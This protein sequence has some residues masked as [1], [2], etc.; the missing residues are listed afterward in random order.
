MKEYT[1]KINIPQYTPK[2]DKNYTVDELVDLKKYNELIANIEKANLSEDDK[3]LLQLAATRHIKFSYKNIAEYYC[4]ADA[5]TQKLMEDSALVII[6]FD[7]AIANGY[8]KLSKRMREIVD[9]SSER[10][11]AYTDAE[12]KQYEA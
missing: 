1:K 7:N 11:E 5:E 9:A 10:P 4:H 12:V 8:L 2:L 6:D 3:R